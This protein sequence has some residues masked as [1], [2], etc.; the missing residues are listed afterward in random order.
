[1]TCPGTSP[2]SSQGREPDPHAAARAAAVGEAFRDTPLLPDTYLVESATRRVTYS[3][4]DLG[5]GGVVELPVP[6][7]ILR[8]TPESNEL[9]RMGGMTYDA[10]RGYDDDEMVPTTT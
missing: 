8:Y 2:P 7:H 3:S 6:R 4:V 9:F 1:M 5:T 10:L